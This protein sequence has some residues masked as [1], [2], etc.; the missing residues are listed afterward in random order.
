M[1]RLTAFL[2]ACSCL[3]SLCACGNQSEDSTVSE[4]FSPIAESVQESEDISDTKSEK[5]DSE[6][7]AETDDTAA[8]ETEEENKETDGA[9]IDKELPDNVSLNTA[10]GVMVSA[11]S[12]DYEHYLTDFAF[13]EKYIVNI[14]EDGESDYAI[15]IGTD[16]ETMMFRLAFPTAND[17]TGETAVIDYAFY[18]NGQDAYSVLNVKSDTETTAEVQHITIEEL[19]NPEEVSQNFESFDWSK[20]GLTYIEYNG[21]QEWNSVIYDTISA[22]MTMNDETVPAVFWFTKEGEFAKADFSDE[23]NG[24]GGYIQ[25]VNKITI[26]DMS[27][28]EM[29]EADEEKFAMSL[30]SIIMTFAFSSMSQADTAEYPLTDEQIAEYG[31]IE[32]KEFL[33]SGYSSSGDTVYVYE[34]VEAEND[35]TESVYYVFNNPEEGSQFMEWY[36]DKDTF[37]DLYL[38]VEYV[39]VGESDYLITKV[40]DH[41]IEKDS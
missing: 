26:P 4:S 15:T 7:T 38:T 19:D 31:T 29:E 37:D 35:I 21:E 33:T 18:K 1:K 22:E 5:T 16:G 17:E 8:K 23:E 28:I 9:T 2:L 34:D 39:A 40:T 24:G 11:E 27:D 32:T 25:A 20:A 10:S 6:T 13:P 41:R 14:G 3:V 30:L 36:S 12:G